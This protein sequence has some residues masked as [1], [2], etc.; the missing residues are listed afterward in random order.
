MRMNVSENEKVKVSKIKEYKNLDLFKNS[1]GIL[2][3]HCNYNSHFGSKDCFT[4]FNQFLKNKYVVN[5]HGFSSLLTH[6][7]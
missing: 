1:Q 3:Y 4:N 6:F 2:K 7:P 5:R